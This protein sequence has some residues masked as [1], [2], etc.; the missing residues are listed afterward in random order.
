MIKFE[1]ESEKVMVEFIQDRFNIEENISLVVS[2]L[3]MRELLDSR[4]FECKS[5]IKEINDEDYIYLISKD[6]TSEGIFLCIEPIT[7]DSGEGYMDMDV[8]ASFIIIQEG[9]LDDDDIDCCV[10]FTEECIIVDY[11]DDCEEELESDEESCLHDCR[12][13]NECDDDEEESDEDTNLELVQ[14]VFN[15]FGTSFNVVGTALSSLKMRLDNKQASEEL[16]ALLEKLV[17]RETG[18]VEIESEDF[19]DVITAKLEFIEDILENYGEISLITDFETAKAIVAEYSIF[20][21]E[22]DFSITLHSDLEGYLVEI[23]EAEI[24][25]IEPIIREGGYFTIET[26]CLYID[27]D[28]D[29]YLDIEFFEHLNVEEIRGVLTEEE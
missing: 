21:F 8:E 13:C 7:F 1:L 3:I 4:T 20:D 10:S 2:K 5:L 12:F 22:D 17:I 29:E 9:L 11:K 25:V 14:A 6:T 23:T 26:E 19:E 16:D 15:K 18:G 24:F 28:I 27:D